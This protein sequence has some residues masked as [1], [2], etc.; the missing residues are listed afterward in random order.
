MNTIDEKLSAF[1]KITNNEFFD[2]S[3]TY[4]GWRVDMTETT[5]TMDELIDVK[6]DAKICKRLKY[7]SVAGFPYA[8]WQ[9]NRAGKGRH[10]KVVSIVDFGDLR[11]YMCADVSKFDKEHKNG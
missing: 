9:V 3:F 6:H 7:G 1:A 10:A 4:W 2:P 5:A 11:V 8:C